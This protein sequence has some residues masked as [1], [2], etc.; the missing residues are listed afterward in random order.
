MYHQLRHGLIPASYLDPTYGLPIAQCPLGHQ[1]VA[2]YFNTLCR[3]TQIFSHYGVVPV[4]IGDIGDI[5]IVRGETLPQ[6]RLLW[7]SF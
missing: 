6:V 1:I 3:N 2:T 7:K 4:S 5:D